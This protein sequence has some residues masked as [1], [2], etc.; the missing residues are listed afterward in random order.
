MIGKL[1]GTVDEILTT[2][3][4]ILDVGGVGYT[5][6]CLS[7]LLVHSKQGE[8]LSLWIEMQTKEDGVTLYGFMNTQ[9]QQ[10]FRLLISVPGVGGKMAMLILNHCKPEE[11]IHHINNSND[12]VFRKISGVGPKLANRLIT[13]L[14]TSKMFKSLSRDFELKDLKNGGRVQYSQQ[15]EDAIVALVNFGFSKILST[16]VVYDV[17]KS[18]LSLDLS[19]I[20]RLSLQKLH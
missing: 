16:Q 10:C 7:Y 17:I 20:I 3:Q 12:G 18:D 15:A 2:D 14:K 4:I 9:E 11:L 19:E 13:E 8:H 6:H 5:I 1:K